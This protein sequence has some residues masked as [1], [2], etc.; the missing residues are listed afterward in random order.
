[1]GHMAAASDLYSHASALFLFLAQEAPSLPLSPAL[2]LSPV[3]CARLHKYQA[4][5]AARQRHC[6]R[7][8]AAVG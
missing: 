7:Q 1:M 3:D 8:V 2:S 5:V 6:S 4:A